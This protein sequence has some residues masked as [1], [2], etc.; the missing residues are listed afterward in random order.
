M[1]QKLT[2]TL[3]YGTMKNDKF[4]TSVLTNEEENSMYGHRKA[5]VDFACAKRAHNSID[6]KKHSYLQRENDVLHTSEGV[7]NT[8]NAGY[9]NDNSFQY[10]PITK[11]EFLKELQKASDTLK[12]ST[13]FK[14]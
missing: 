14:A 6:A 10:D 11:D 4:I 7:I 1:K 13:Y 2:S 12:L 9:L 5:Q 3:L 8:L